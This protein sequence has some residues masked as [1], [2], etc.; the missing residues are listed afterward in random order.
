MLLIVCGLK[1]G[2]AFTICPPR[3]WY[4][5]SKYAS[6]CP[7]SSFLPAWR[8]II[9]AKVSPRPA[10]ME[11]RIAR[12]GSNWYERSGRWQTSVLNRPRSSSHEAAARA[13]RE[14]NGGTTSGRFPCR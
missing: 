9:T 12:A 14:R 11:S 8:A 13:A 10:R 2:E 5:L 7:D 3:R 6:S 4:R 1:V